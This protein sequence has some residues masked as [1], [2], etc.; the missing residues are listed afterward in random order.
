MKLWEMFEGVGG[1]FQ[2]F[3]EVVEVLDKKDD[4]KLYACKIMALP[5]PN[6]ELSDEEMTR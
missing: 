5:R 1:C 3:A 4:D 2:G 6:A